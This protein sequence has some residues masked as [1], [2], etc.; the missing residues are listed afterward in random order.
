MQNRELRRA[1]TIDLI[2]DVIRTNHFPRRY[3]ELSGQEKFC[4]LELLAKAS[5]SVRKIG[6]CVYADG[7]VSWSRKLNGYEVYT[8]R[9]AGIHRRLR[10]LAHEIGHIILHLDWRVGRIPAY[11]CEL[12]DASSLLAYEYPDNEEDEARYFVERLLRRNG[13]PRFRRKAKK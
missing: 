11:P 13:K 5:L 1:T 8:D 3:D 10:I 2:T 6:K 9:K 7:K 4:C 12:L